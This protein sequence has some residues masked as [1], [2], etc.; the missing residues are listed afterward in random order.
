MTYNMIYI[1]IFTKKN[2]MFLYVLNA[3]SVVH[4]CNMMQ[5][6]RHLLPSTVLGARIS[7]SENQSPTNWLELLPASSRKWETLDLSGKLRQNSQNRRLAALSAYQEQLALEGTFKLRLRKKNSAPA[8]EA[9]CFHDVQ[10]QAKLA[11]ACPDGCD[12]AC[13]FVWLSKP[14]ED[15]VIF[16]SSLWPLL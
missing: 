3:V 7:S 1:Y 10:K 2:T 15:M 13:C 9:F 12:H 4:R 14:V 6:C 11:L 16:A 8:L 5:L